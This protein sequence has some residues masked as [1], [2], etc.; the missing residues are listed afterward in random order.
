ML[1][2][3]AMVA[4]RADAGQILLSLG[5][6]GLLA[7]CAAPPMG[8]TVQVMPGPGRSF[9]AF[10]ADQ[11]YCQYYA[12]QQVQGQA[13]AANQHAAGGAVLGTLLG[14]GLGAAVG[15]LGGNV[16]AGAVIGAA[17]GASGGA[18]YGANAST[19]AQYGIQQRYDNAFAQCMYA[20]GD[21]VPGY[22]PRVIYNA[23]PASAAPYPY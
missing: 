4:H 13:E 14:A 20:R 17:A 16:G 15:S 6:L 3:F 21:Q 9:E 10:Q 19:Y 5:I 23:P 8:P 18:V 2:M 22:A 12:S 11:S 1:K 7:G